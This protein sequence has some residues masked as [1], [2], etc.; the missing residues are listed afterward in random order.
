MYI[1]NGRSKSY[2]SQLVTYTS[3]HVW[4]NNT[5]GQVMCNNISKY[6][7]ISVLWA[8]VCE[9]YFNC[10]GIVY[11]IKTL[12]EADS[13]SSVQSV[14]RITRFSSNESLQYPGDEGWLL[15]PDLCIPSSLSLCSSRRCTCHN[16]NITAEMISRNTLDRYIK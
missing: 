4:K 6:V 15:V 12:R 10:V 8:C 2:L 3:A 1:R 9:V 13:L 16:K 7:S 11:L 5:A 14:N